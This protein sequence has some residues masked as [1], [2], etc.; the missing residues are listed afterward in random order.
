MRLASNKLSV[1]IALLLGASR[2]L[3]AQSSLPA[4]ANDCKHSVNKSDF[5]SRTD[6][7]FVTDIGYSKVLRACIVVSEQGFPTARHQID[8]TTYIHNV[9]I[10]NVADSSIVWKDERLIRQG[11][12]A[13]RYPALE[14][15]LTRLDVELAHRK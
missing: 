15:E 14:E 6:G 11:H 7:P 5:E 3:C 1:L 4:N 12:H 2:I 8:M 10:H 9:S 13:D